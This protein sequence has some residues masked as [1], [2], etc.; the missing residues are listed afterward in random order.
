MERLNPP[1]PAPPAPVISSWKITLPDSLNLPN[2]PQFV[3][4]GPS[5]PRS[6]RG[7]VCEVCLVPQADS[8]LWLQGKRPLRDPP[9]PTP[10]QVC[11]CLCARLTVCSAASQA[12]EEL[13]ESL[14]LE[15]S[16][17]HMGLSRVSP[18][19]ADTDPGLIPVLASTRKVGRYLSNKFSISQ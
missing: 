17:Y 3:L 16:N 11:F 10:E 19:H 8:L 6:G 9:P 14:D 4:L 15:K 5:R 2:N 1:P 13:L 7:R 12:V 18:V